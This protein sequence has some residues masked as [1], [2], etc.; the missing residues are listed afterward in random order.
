MGGRF[1]NG[2][3]SCFLFMCSMSRQVLPC[4]P[5]WARVMA[6]RG[7]LWWAPGGPS[8]HNG[9][10]HALWGPWRLRGGAGGV[11]GSR[12]PAALAGLLAAVGA[13]AWGRRRGGSG[14]RACACV[15]RRVDGGRRTPRV[16]VG[17]V[18][19]LGRAALRGRLRARRRAACT[20]GGGLI[21]ATAALLPAVH[22]LELSQANG[23]PDA[24]TPTLE[25]TTRCGGVNG[26]DHD[27]LPLRR[28]VLR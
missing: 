26:V 21:A 18:A 4:H 27:G 3:R 14:T 17:G 15:H 9:R 28:G 12:A 10:E 25:G 22:A 23:P 19:G 8:R 20:G 5:A 7:A 2:A 6:T 16:G 1:Y 24:G 13:P 11:V